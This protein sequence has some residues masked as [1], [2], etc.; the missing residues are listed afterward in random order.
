MLLPLSK[1]RWQQISSHISEYQKIGKIA[2]HKVPVQKY[3]CTQNSTYYTV[4]KKCLETTVTREVLIKRHNCQD[5]SKLATQYRIFSGN[6]PI[7]NII[8]I[9]IKADSTKMKL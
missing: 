6:S 1:R 4:D 8:R 2:T 5:S 9:Q 7:I 3:R